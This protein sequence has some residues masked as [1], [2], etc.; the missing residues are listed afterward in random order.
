M[1]NELIV[2]V[3]GS[4]QVLSLSGATAETIRRSQA[5]APV[6]VNAVT[7][8]LLNA[9]VLESSAFSSR[10][11]MKAGAIGVEAGVAVFAMPAVAAASSGPNGET[12]GYEPPAGVQVLSA[13]NEWGR[14]T[15][16]NIL[17]SVADGTHCFFGFYL[18][19]TLTT[20]Q[21]RQTLYFASFQ[22]EVSALDDD[23]SNPDWTRWAEFFSAISSLS[24]GLRQFLLNEQ[25]SIPRVSGEK[26][27][28]NFL[29]VE[30]GGATYAVNDVAWY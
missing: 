16:M 21:T 9:G 4:T 23:I 24:S 26:L 2:M 19:T 27:A 11:L 5:G 22:E 29:D 30:W 8:E 15:N 17:S 12:D 3:P 14:R 6:L 1:G 10:G 7:D 28:D 13:F 25:G 18:S 20:P